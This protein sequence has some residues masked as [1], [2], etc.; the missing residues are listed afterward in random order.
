MKILLRLLYLKFV[1]I[2][3]RLD[4][5][6]IPLLPNNAPL[7]IK[8]SLK[9]VKYLFFWHRPA[10]SNPRRLALALEDLGPIFIKFGQMLSTRPD[11]I[12]YEYITELS[13]LQEQ[14]TPLNYTKVIEPI[15]KKNYPQ[16]PF[17][18]I[19]EKAL[20]SASIAQIHRATTLDDNEVILKIKKPIAEK[21]INIDSKTLRFIAT[22]LEKTLP[23]LKRFS[24]VILIDNYQKSLQEELNF[25][26]EIFNTQTLRNNFLNSENL[27]VPKTYLDLCTDEIIVLEFMQHPRISEIYDDNATDKE[28]LANKGVEIFFTQVFE[29]NFFHAD[30]H[31]GNILINK[32][33]P[34]NPSYIA[35]DC[36]V[37]GSLSPK[38]QIYIAK[39]LKA[40]FDRDYKKIA[41]LHLMA[42]WIPKDTP[43]QLFRQYIESICAPL[44][45]KPL[46][47]IS[48][49]NFLTQLFIVAQ[50]FSIP[51]QPQLILLQKTLL[52]VEGL[53][54]QLYP[55]LDLWKTAQPFINR[56]LIKQYNPIEHLKSINFHPTDLLI[57]I[58]CIH[59]VI[60]QNLQSP[61]ITYQIQSEQR[62]TI[63]SIHSTV[64]WLFVIN[65]SLCCT[66]ISFILYT[67]P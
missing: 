14:T 11:L 57:Y 47:E 51:I 23:E 44:N 56:W 13:C 7:L 10:E 58:N 24:P 32:N 28:I 39:N 12:G 48:F 60:K 53:G 15:I 41:D 16:F 55:Q 65:I 1:F 2:K 33:K 49:A 8:I 31:P 9:S 30:M 29:H 17:K 63:Q 67:Y 36:A 46:A 3:F 52:Y 43:M 26:Q 20:A 40:F 45:E 64:K 38:D 19:S 22:V 6:I 21:L 54:R 35:L 25:R 59:E 5:I 62:K 66:F 61:Q 37:I 50:Q 42:G 4:Q 27:Y 34:H 18:N